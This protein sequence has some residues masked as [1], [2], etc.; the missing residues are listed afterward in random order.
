MNTTPFVQSPAI[1]KLIRAW[2]AYRNH[3]M[4]RRAVIAARS[5]A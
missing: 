3:S 5:V 2:L 4:L 1:A